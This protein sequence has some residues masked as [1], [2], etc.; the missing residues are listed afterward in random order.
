MSGEPM[1]VLLIEDN[2]GDARLIREVLA[3]AVGTRF[4]LVHVEQLSQG[5]AYVTD[6]AAAGKIALA[7][8]LLDLSLPDSQGL[9]TLTRF[10]A[11]APQLPIIVLTGLKD[12]RLRSRLCI[13]ARRTTWSKVRLIARI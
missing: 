2:S 10:C 13:R 7:V 1:R 5:L 4:N 9:D 11:H 3:D 6:D 8:V 12:E